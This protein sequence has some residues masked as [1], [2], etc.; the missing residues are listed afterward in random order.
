MATTPRARKPAVKPKPATKPV[1]ARPALH[2]IPAMI[3]TVLRVSERIALQFAQ[4][5]K[6]NRRKLLRFA[7]KAA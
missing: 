4:I 1:A 6:R 2:G 3:D 7:P 5:L